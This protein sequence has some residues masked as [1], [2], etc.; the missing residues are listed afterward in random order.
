MAVSFSRLLHNARH[1]S[2]YSPQSKWLGIELEGTVYTCRLRDFD[3][4]RFK[5]EEFAG[6]RNFTTFVFPVGLV[7]VLVTAI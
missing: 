5:V 1:L 6:I 4:D 2:A 7:V 3:M